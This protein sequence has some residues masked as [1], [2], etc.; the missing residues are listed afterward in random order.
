MSV[1]L[2]VRSKE[3]YEILI[4]VDNENNTAEVISAIK[5]TG[6]SYVI[7][8]DPNGGTGDAME[9][10][11]VKEGLSVILKTCSY[12]RSD[13]TFVG[14]C[15]DAKGQGEVYSGKASYEPKKDCYTI[16]YLGI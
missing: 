2:L 10:Q 12:T 7:T 11:T 1:F 4:K 8:Y 6:K 13:Y 16:C 3:G 9:G 14:W 15:E 5:G